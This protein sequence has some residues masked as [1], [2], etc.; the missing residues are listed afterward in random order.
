M[1]TAYENTTGNVVFLFECLALHLFILRASSIHQRQAASECI[2]PSESEIGFREPFD[3]ET[4]VCR[5]WRSVF[6]FVLPVTHFCNAKRNKPAGC[7]DFCRCA[8]R[9]R[10]RQRNELLGVVVHRVD[11]AAACGMLNPGR[12]AICGNVFSM[13]LGLLT[14]RLPSSSSQCS[15]FHRKTHSPLVTYVPCVSFPT[16]RF[17][18]HLL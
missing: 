18:P 15:P 11:I 12:F 2:S 10:T 3:W 17:F 14:A 4:T 5:G 8:L 6:E 9:P 13:E 16:R 7:G 1:Q